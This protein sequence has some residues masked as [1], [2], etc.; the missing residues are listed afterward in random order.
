MKNYY[1]I[2]ALVFILSFVSVQAATITASANNGDWTTAS[3]WNLNRIPQS[4]DT[5]IIPAG[6]TVNV[7]TNVSVSGDVVVQV[8]GTLKFNHSAKLNISAASKIILSV[9]GM[10]TSNGSASDQ[11][12]IGGSTIWKGN[13][14]NLIGAMVLDN[15]GLHQA[16]GSS[17]PVKFVSFTLTHK[18]ADVLVQWSTAQETKSSH[19][20]IERSENGKDWIGIGT[21]K[22]AGESTKLINYTYTDK[23]VA[24]T[25]LYYRIKQVDI[26][27]AHVYTPVKAIKMENSNTGIAV[28]VSTNKTIV[29]NFSQ[30]FRSTVTM[31]LI[32]ASGQVVAQQNTTNP[33]GQVVFAAANNSNGFYVVNI[34]DGKGLS[35][36]KQ[37]L[38]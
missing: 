35:F 31:R 16:S 15:A 32:A 34:T 20:T 29:L 19:F 26:D 7:F 21:V 13:A 24:G 14:G 37:V 12:R 25:M 28:M 10:I 11:I 9:G 18:Q 33:S 3:T 22:A 27:G 38:L 4:G 5:I 17:L 23:K 36:S 6:K 2:L 1:P 8:A 30:Q